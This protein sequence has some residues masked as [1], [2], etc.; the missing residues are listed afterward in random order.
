MAQE[1]QQQPPAAPPAK[2]AA[3]E[4]EIR[5]ARALAERYRCEFVDLKEAHIAQDVL[6]SVPVDLMFRYN[7]VPLAA[8]NGTLEIAL[9]DPRNLNL[10]DELSI[11]LDKKLRIKVAALQQISDLLK[12]TEQ[13]QR[14]LEE[15]T[16]T[17]SLDVVADEENSDET[18]SIDKLSA[19]DSDIAPVIKLVDTTIFNALERRASDIHIET[20]DAEVVIKYRIDGVLNYAMPPIS[21]E[22]HST[23]ISRIKVMSELDIAERRVPQDGRFRVRYKTRLIDFRVSIMPTVHGEDAVLRVLDKESMNEKFSKLT[24]DVVGFD[25]RDIVKFRRYIKEPYGMVL[26]T[27]PTG[28]GKTT[29]LYAAISEIKTDEDKIITIEDPVE[30]QL[31]GITQIPVNEK[32]GLTFARG[33]RSILR[34]DPDKIMV[35]EIRDQET[36]QIAINAALTGHLVFTTVHAN[37]V[38]DVLGRFLNMGVEPYNFVSAMNCILAQRLV[39]LI[40]EHCKRPVKYPDEVLEESGLNVE[41]WRNVTCY[42]G[43]GCFECG[44]TGYHGRTAIHELLDLSEKVR[45][46]ILDRRPASEIKRQAREEG[47]TFLRESAIEK[48]RLGLSTLKEINKVTFIEG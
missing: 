18:L 22:W 47:M 42:E 35:G 37:N 28:S 34:H 12:K 11:L 29:T 40:C 15:V 9:S 31:K 16:E 39:R 3:R 25:P 44:G 26:V 13:S 41:E 43:A 19:V 5:Q 24:L 33:L 27:G 1:P 21:K 38:L 32:K 10:V 30:Y 4:A 45:E 20:R 6:K 23:I 48:V 36:A 7:F 2:T 46:M 8:H 14:V 17:F